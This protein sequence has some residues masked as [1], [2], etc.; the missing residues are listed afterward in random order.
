M[1]SYSQKV[2]AL[3]MLLTTCVIV[4]ANEI[5]RA[6]APVRAMAETESILMKRDSK[7]LGGSNSV[8]I[9]EQTFVA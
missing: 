3:G 4:N 7:G 5:I 6:W 1:P 2:M 8:S 9:E